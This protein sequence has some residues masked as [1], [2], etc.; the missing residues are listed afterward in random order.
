MQ[1]MQSANIR[2]V[3]WFIIII[4]IIIIIIGPVRQKNYEIQACV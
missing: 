2:F 4:I 3:F 1:L